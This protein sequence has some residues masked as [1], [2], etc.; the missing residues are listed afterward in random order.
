MNATNDT[1][2]GYNG[3]TMRD[4]LVGDFLAGLKAAAGLDDS[5][6][7]AP[8]RYVA[9]KGSGGDAAQEIEDALWL[10]TVWEMFGTNESYSS[11]TYET[12]ANQ[13][14]L[15]YYIDNTKRIKYDSAN[16]DKQYW[17][18][19]PRASS[20][21]IFALVYYGGSAYYHTASAVY[22]CAPAFCVR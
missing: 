18:A 1:S 10:P 13:A 3:T 21:L 17:L 4:Y 9:N 2:A 20:S 7:W 22:G 8:T 14:R 12:A 6:L 15:E 11:A 16:S 5:M 19:S